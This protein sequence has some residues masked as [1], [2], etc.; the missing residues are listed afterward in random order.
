MHTRREAE[1]ASSEG[2]AVLRINNFVFKCLKTVCKSSFLA[3][4]VAAYLPQNIKIRGMADT[5]YVG[6]SDPSLSLPSLKFFP[7][8]PFFFGYFL[9][10][11]DNDEVLCTNEPVILAAVIPFTGIS[12]IS[13][14]YTENGLTRKK[15][16]M[17]SKLDN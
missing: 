10:Y 13:R 8:L 16:N 14:I 3:K 15:Y 17:V 2:E 7:F 11:S 9:C 1:R 6:I 5:G 12:W 4:Y